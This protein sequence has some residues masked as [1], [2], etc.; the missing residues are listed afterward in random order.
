MPF[1]SKAIAFLIVAALLWILW[2]FYAITEL[3]PRVQMH[4]TFY[5]W[6]TSWVLCL[7][8]PS[9]LAAALVFR[10]KHGK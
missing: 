4:W 7:L 10:I 8:P 2:C 5:P 6:L 3:T 1:T 9:A